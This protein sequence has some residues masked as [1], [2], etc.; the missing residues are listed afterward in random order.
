MAIFPGW[1]PGEDAQ[2]APPR[3]WT[4]L[5][6]SGPWSHFQNW[7][8]VRPTLPLCTD[9]RQVILSPYTWF[10]PS[11]L[12]HILWARSILWALSAKDQRAGGRGAARRRP[13]DSSPHGKAGGVSAFYLE[14]SHGKCSGFPGFGGK[15]GDENL[16]RFNICYQ[17]II[18]KESVLLK[19][20]CPWTVAGGSC[21][22]AKPRR[23]EGPHAPGRGLLPPGSG[24]GP[25]PQG[26]AGCVHY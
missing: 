8:A 24:A 12:C 14:R 17:S 25:F 19:T 15:T 20:A 2:A 13:A 21:G 10:L 4:T 9:P 16:K 7:V 1:C 26:L 6:T 23:V 18:F 5:E 11:S 22:Y 3:K